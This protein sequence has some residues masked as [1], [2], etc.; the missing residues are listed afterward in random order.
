[1]KKNKIRLAE[2]EAAA[3]RAVDDIYGINL[4][5]GDIE[6]IICGRLGFNLTDGSAV[7]ESV[8]DAEKLRMIYGINKQIGEITGPWI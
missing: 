3:R 6:A 7:K 5:Y 2:L 8:S 4:L 1:M